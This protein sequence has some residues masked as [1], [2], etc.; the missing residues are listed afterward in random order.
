MAEIKTI[1]Q[2]TSELSS[3]STMVFIHVLN[4]V[5]IAEFCSFIPLCPGKSSDSSLTHRFI[6]LYF[7][8]MKYSHR[9]WQSHQP[10][11][12][13]VPSLP[14]T[15]MAAQAVGY[16]ECRPVSVVLTGEEHPGA[17]SMMSSSQTVSLKVPAVPHYTASVGA[18]CSTQCL[19]QLFVL[20]NGQDGSLSISLVLGCCEFL[21]F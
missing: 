3:C 4:M 11:I 9:T 14:R 7:F 5:R 8:C 13:Q 20:S 15:G 18:H 16:S 17:S 10:D 21:W 19:L 1:F 6:F 2:K 12:S